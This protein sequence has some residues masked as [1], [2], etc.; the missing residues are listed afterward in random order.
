MKI[1]QKV[2]SI[3]LRS[4]NV[5]KFANKAHEAPRVTMRPIAL[6]LL[7]GS[8]KSAVLDLG[9]M[10]EVEE[11]LARRNWMVISRS[12]IHSVVIV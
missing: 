9:H 5:A 3:I 2:N 8:C 11:G 4:A 7:D 12:S 1:K 10:V 6:E